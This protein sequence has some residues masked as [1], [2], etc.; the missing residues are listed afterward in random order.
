MLK[1]I[2]KTPPGYDRPTLRRGLRFLIKLLETVMVPL[3]L[4]VL[5]LVPRRL[6]MLVPLPSSPSSTRPSPGSVWLFEWSTGSNGISPITVVDLRSRW[7]GTSHI[8][9]SPCYAYCSFD[10]NLTNI[11]L[12]EGIYQIY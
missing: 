8:K 9:P 3:H 5:V 7:V 2:K 10:K 4:L 11:C 12:D 6:M 1:Q